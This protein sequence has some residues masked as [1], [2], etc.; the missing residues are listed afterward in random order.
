[1]SLHSTGRSA[2]FVVSGGS[3]TVATVSGVTVEESSTSSLDVSDTANCPPP[4]SHPYSLLAFRQGRLYPPPGNFSLHRDKRCQPSTL[5]C[6]NRVCYN[7]KPDIIQ[8]GMVLFNLKKGSPH[9]SFPLHFTLGGHFP[10]KVLSYITKDESRKMTDNYLSSRGVVRSEDGGGSGLLVTSERLKVGFDQFGRA[11]RIRHRSFVFV[12]PNSR[13]TKVP[14]VLFNS[15]KPNNRKTGCFLWRKTTP[16]IRYKFV[17][18]RLKWT[19]TLFTQRERIVARVLFIQNLITPFI[20][21]KKKSIQ[22][23]PRRFTLR[24]SPPKTLS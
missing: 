15:P 20:T 8:S 5:N 18:Y 9:E 17:V 3:A 6:E 16:I 7:I 22:S 4:F 11:N 13:S 23:F 12:I 21:W 1:M 24:G 19:K 10:S 2:A 14:Y